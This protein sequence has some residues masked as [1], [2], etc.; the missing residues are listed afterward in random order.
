[1]KLTIRLR[2]YTRLG[3]SLFL[4]G[5]HER[6]GGGRQENALP[7]R[8]V[9]E[10]FWEAALEFPDSPLPDTPLS[11]YFILRNPD[12]PVVEDF[13]ADRKLDLARLTGG[14]AVVIDSWNDLA[15]VENVF[16]TEPFK[17]VLLRTEE[18]AGDATPP[19]GATH[20]F[21]VK[22][23]LLPKGQ[24]LCLLGSAGTMGAWNQA[25]PVLL[26]RSPGCFSVRLDLARELFPLAYKYGVYDTERKAF[27][28][29][30][31]GDN[32][33]LAEPAS[34]GSQVIVND[35]F[36]RLPGKP[37]RGA[38]VAIPVFSLRSE[39]SFGV[40]EFLD[41][42]LL[43]DWARR[44]GLK[45]IQILP[46][47]DTCA[48]H[49]AADSYPYAAISA[50][51]LHPLYLN[52]DR[53]AGP[54]NRLPEA[55]ARLRD[56]LNKLET[57]DYVAVMEAKLAFLRNIFPARQMETLACAEYQDFCAQNQHWLAP[58]A[59]FCFLRDKF[60]TS[61]SGQWRE[62]RV[63]DA[64]EI[65]TLAARDSTAR[66]EMDFHCF[67]QFHL[68]S[69]LRE[70]AEYLHSQ[71]LILK[72][73][74]AI[75]VHRHGADVWQ[76]PELFNTDMQAGAPPDPF[77]AKGQNWGFPTYNW[78]RMKQ[79]G[80][81]WWKQ[82]LAQMGC[83]FDAFRIDHI[84]GFFRIWSI[85]Q[86]AVEGILGYFV[87]AIP[88]RPGEFAA[89]DIAFDHERFARPFIDDPV[90]REFFGDNAQSVARQFLNPLAGGTYSPKPEFA[91]QRDVEKHF[92][93]PE[94]SGRDA[95]LKEG[96]FDLISNVLMIETPGAEFHFRLGMEQT[97]SFR[98]L[99]ENIQAQM[100]ELYADYFF[101]RQDD[102]WRR[103]GLQKLPALKRVTNM[104]ICGEDLGM[105]PVCVPEVMKELALLSLEIQRMPKSSNTDFSPPA[106]APYLSVVTPATHDMSTIRGWWLEDKA[107]T[108]KFFNQQLLQAGPAPTQCEPWINRDIV[109]Q[110]LDSPAMWSIFQ[111]QD[112][113]GMD[114]ALRRVDVD[115]ERINVPA[116]SNYYWR[117]RMHLP[118]EALVRAENFNRQVEDMVRRSGR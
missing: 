55:L 40:G 90:L 52:L 49:T 31:A 14:H 105:V 50:F 84:L 6:L 13:G 102:F 42:P 98:Q 10:E 107:I 25:A 109:R 61:D 106:D 1:M 87:P 118:L 99:D 35:G 44:T 46:V 78:Q 21:N 5:D 32:R 89:R 43:A 81:A 11:Y 12:G 26:R 112:L 30:E 28:R 73:D 69:Q 117:Y 108:Q 77:A 83:Y 115:A 53:L 19:G 101:R 59:A 64:T 58:Y 62:H 82:R 63:Y 92:A 80:F 100:K 70:A 85:P 20:W 22:A 95:G 23:P 38:G 71:A 114:A 88:V 4:C 2:Y 113:L 47:N 45:L 51:A 72:G 34:Q 79:D 96:L 94:N 66:D 74:I 111:L 104:L 9:N 3:Q 67:I 116:V 7:L 103:Q 110:H 76:Q 17:T 93:L 29:Y 56:R 65:N 16:F 18:E 15:T 27:V 68:H 60:G 36:A 41:L 39:K 57:V 48:N 33:V 37:W 97:S 75:G 24:T 54:G 86:S 8:Y 91:T